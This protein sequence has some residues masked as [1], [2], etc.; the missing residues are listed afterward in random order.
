MRDSG[1]IRRVFRAIPAGSGPGAAR[2]SGIGHF[3]VA[4]V[5]VFTSVATIFSTIAGLT[6]FQTAFSG[7]F[8]RSTPGKR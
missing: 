7:V 4:A 5:A 3:F 8:W 1:W 2:F 6:V